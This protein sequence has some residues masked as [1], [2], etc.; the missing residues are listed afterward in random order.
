MV[1]YINMSDKKTSLNLSPIVGVLVNQID[2]RY[3][4]VIYKSMLD[5]TRKNSLKLLFFVGRALNS[6]YAGEEQY[7]RIYELAKSNKIN[8]L[9]VVSGSLGNYIGPEGLLEYLKLFPEIPKVSLSFKLNNI[10]SVLIDNYNG[11]KELITHLIITHGYRK[12]AFIRGQ[13][14]NPEAEERFRAYKETLQDFGILFRDELVFQ[15]DFTYQ[16]GY[17]FSKTILKKS[18]TDFEVVVCSND[19][20]AI[21][22][23]SG[24]E[25]NNDPFNKIHVT[26]FDDIVESR[27]ITPSLTTVRCPIYEQAYVA[28]KVIHDM[29]KGKEVENEVYLKGKFIIRESC[30]CFDA[31]HNRFINISFDSDDSYISEKKTIIDSLLLSKIICET[32]D[33]K[34]NETPLF[35][36]L[37]QNILDAFS[38]DLT[39]IPEND[40]FSKELNFALERSLYFQYFGEIWQTTL[41]IL[42]EYTYKRLENKTSLLSYAI[43]LIQKGEIIISKWIEK[44][45]FLYSQELFGLLYHLRRTVKKINSVFSEKAF[46]DAI[47]EELKLL[48]LEEFYLCLFSDS[49]SLKKEKV[50]IALPYHNK[51]IKEIEGIE[52]ESNEILPEMILNDKK[53]RVYILMSLCNR[54]KHFGYVAFNDPK[55]QPIVFEFLREQISSAIFSIRLFEERE[56]TAKELQK[57]LEEVRK[58]ELRFKEM[59]LLLPTII[60]DIDLNGRISFINQAGLEFLE[61]NEKDLGNILQNVQDKDRERFR[62]DIFSV[63]DKKEGLSFY[64]YT[65]ISRRGVEKPIIAKMIPIGKEK[66]GVRINAFNLEL[67][68]SS[69]IMP[70]EDFFEK[71]NIT[72]REKEIILLMLQSYRIKDIAARLFIAEST[73]KGHISQIYSK[74]GVNNKSELLEVLEKYKVGYSDYYSYLLSKLD[75]S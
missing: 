24:L 45:E 33:L 5:Y 17:N 31:N 18:L 48:N 57:I 71:F 37:L 56:K 51:V 11:M 16:Y 64:E 2:G 75:R 23:L 13:P 42:R 41:L 34:Q 1:K 36:Y 63:L 3:Q 43:D 61:T 10:P 9:I 38:F 40:F 27:D 49:Y 52:I 62:K 39:N 21:G 28:C 30:G 26:G 65:F 70:K 20:M 74:V 72:D 12:L 55:L 54:D 67:L 46:F 68:R 58:S 19:E 15:G 32:V 47:A 25:K 29:I 8:G 59:A 73:V 7:N 53:G 14:Q 6:P 60:I 22:L 4:S 50:N 44:K 66:N 35:S 69:F